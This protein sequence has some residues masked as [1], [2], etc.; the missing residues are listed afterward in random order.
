MNQCIKEAI[1]DFGEPLR[2]VKTP[3]RSELLHAGP[4]AK[5]LPI[6]IKPFYSI[7][8]GPLQQKRCAFYHRIPIA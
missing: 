7:V 4:K 2:S 8:C 6:K 3:T 5:K 1:N